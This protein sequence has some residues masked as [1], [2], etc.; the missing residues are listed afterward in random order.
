MAAKISVMVPVYNSK[1]Y[2]QECLDSIFSQNYENFEVVVSDDASTDGGQEILKKYAAQYK[3]MILLLNENNLGITDNC[4]QALQACDGKY[5]VL[6]AGDDVMLPGK[7]SMQVEFMESHPDVAISYHSVEVF[8]S[9]TN[10]VLGYTS[11]TPADETNNTVDIITKM[12][13]DGSMSIMSRSSMVPKDIYKTDVKY[14]SDWL[15]QIEVSL[16]GRV[17]MLPGV[18]CKYRKYGTNNGKDLSRYLHEFEEVIGYVKTKYSKNS[19]LV[20]ACNVGLARFLAGEAFRNIAAGQKKQAR[21]NL[22]RA[23]GLDRKLI[24]V[25]A[26][27]FAFVPLGASVLQKMKYSLKKVLSRLGLL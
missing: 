15:F 14:I 26:Y 18:W 12:G 10:T 23:I 24:Y 3:N 8:N 16:A 6:F 17:V 7:L 21:T 25:V 5:I 27:L 4:D 19:Q 13:I 22:K 1:E 11:S 2:L 9:D 20:N